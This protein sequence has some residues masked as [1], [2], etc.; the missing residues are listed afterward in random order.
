MHPNKVPLAPVGGIFLIFVTIDQEHRTA[1]QLIGFT[2]IDE[3]SAAR[4][5][6]SKKQLREGV[7][8]RKIGRA[9]LKPRD[10]VQQKQRIA[11]KLRRCMSCQLND[12]SGFKRLI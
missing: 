5:R 1:F 8:F 2:L 3:T 6:I 7:P 12:L 10:A 9:C 11:E 4:E